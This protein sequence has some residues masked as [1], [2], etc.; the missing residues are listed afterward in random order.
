MPL[1]LASEF[2]E[3]FD[4]S[5]SLFPKSDNK[6]V[7][8]IN[9]ASIGEGFELNYKTEIKPFENDGYFCELYDLKDKTS[10][11]V[12]QK[13]QNVSIC[14]VAGGNT[15]Y[16]LEH[17]QK[18]NFGEAIKKRL[19]DDN[20]LYIGSSAGSILMSPDIN[21]IAPMD[22]KEKSNLETTQSIGLISFSF[23]PHIGHPFMGDAAKNIKNTYCD[24]LDLMCFNDNQAIYIDG[25]CV[26]IL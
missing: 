18:S 4:K 20:F 17:V 26:E 21:F 14:Y 1:L 16:L 9:T 2:R 15:F 25:N 7:L 12:E 23:L 6:K 8:I 19:K 11:D 24:D 3:V 13:L 22:A 10:V 5:K